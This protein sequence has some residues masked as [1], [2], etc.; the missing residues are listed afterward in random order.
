MSMCQKEV[1]DK[2]EASKLVDNELKKQNP[3]I[4]CVILDD[5]TIEKAWGWVFFYQSKAFIDSGDFRDML[6]GN[7]PLIVNRSSGKIIETGTAYEIEHYIKEYE[8]N[9]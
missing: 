2:V 8:A 5:E 6:G 7:A 1:M 9:L 4:D 3:D